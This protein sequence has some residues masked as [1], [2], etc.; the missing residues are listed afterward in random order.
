MAQVSHMHQGRVEYDHDN[1]DIP[2]RCILAMTVEMQGI[3]F[4]ECFNVQI[5]WVVTRDSADEKTLHVQAGLFVNF[6]QHTM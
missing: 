3:P 2:I 4:A 5:R 1:D 6:L